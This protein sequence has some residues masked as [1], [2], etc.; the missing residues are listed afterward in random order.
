MKDIKLL[1][2]WTAFLI[3]IQLMVSCSKGD[4]E[5]L[6][7]EKQ[8]EYYLTDVQKSIF[9]I[10]RKDTILTFYSGEIDSIELFLVGIQNYLSYPVSDTRNG[11]SMIVSYSSE[12]D[13]LPNFGIAYDLLA[14]EDGSCQL[15]II[16][17]TGTYWNERANDFNFSNFYL[18]PF[19]NSSDSIFASQVWLK[20]EYNSSINID[21]ETFTNVFYLPNGTWQGFGLVANDCYYQIENGVIAFTDVNEKYWMIK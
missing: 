17:V 6:D 11:E 9:D 12:T 13:Y 21:S 5:E 2:L 16:F 8:V 1:L 7:K 10:F 19:N 18:N 15:S 20:Y 3:L 14:L 4:N